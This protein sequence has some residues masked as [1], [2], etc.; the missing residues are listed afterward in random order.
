MNEVK[1]LGACVHSRKAYT[2]VDKHI[3][4]DDLSDRGQIVYDEIKRWYD[5][6]PDAQRCDPDVIAERLFEAYP[7]HEAV[8]KSMLQG[9]EPI[10][11]KN[12][13]AAFLEFKANVVSSKLIQALAAKDTK[14]ADVL[15][16]EYREL[17]SGTSEVQEKDRKVYT[18]SKSSALVESVRPENLMALHPPSL[19]DAIGGGLPRGSHTLIFAPPEVGKSLLSINISSGFLHDGRTVLYIGNEDPA[20]LM[21]LRFKSRLTGR[22]R[23]EILKDPDAADVVAARHGFDNLIFASLAPGGIRD[24]EQLCDEYRPDVVVVDQ[25]SNLYTPN[26]SKVEALEWLAKQMRSI[27]KSRNIVGISIT[28]A[29]DSAQNKLVLDMGDVYFSNVAIQAQVDVMIGIG[30]DK[31]AEAAGI[32]M[33]SLCKNKLNGNHQPVQVQVIPELSKVR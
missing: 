20:E 9:M 22:P 7:K 8:F 23:G 5:I 12:I 2:V 29:A 25:L 21:L 26:L 16:Q 13:T 14:L 31:T 30:M 17:L 28:Q 32:R 1:I 33:L 3:K 19:N 4:S 18:K 6:D 15:A 10:S 11:D 27:C 24:V